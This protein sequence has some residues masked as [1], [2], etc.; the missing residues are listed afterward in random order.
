MD[1]SGGKLDELQKRV[2]DSLAAVQPPFILGG[3]GALA[4]VHLAHRKTRDLDLFWREQA[5]LGEIP[6]L[7]EARLIQEGLSVSP[8]QRSPLFVRL[9]VADASS[10]VVVDLISEPTSSLEPPWRCRIGRSEILVDTPHAILTEK[11]CALLER[12]ELRDLIDVEA[13][14]RS[15]E[16]LNSAVADAPR[17]DTGFSPLTLAWVLRDWDV[18]RVASSAAMSDADAEMLEDFRLSLIDRLIAPDSTA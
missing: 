12:S 11:L 9:R 10:V 3:G 6:G 5:E 16:D 4:G 14:V 18:R 1:T 17:R 2:L 7:I 13:L 15:G 8:L